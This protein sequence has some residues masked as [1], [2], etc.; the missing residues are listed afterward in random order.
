[1]YIYIYMYIYIFYIYVY[2][3]ITILIMILVSKIVLDAGSQV[4]KGEQKRESMKDYMC[5]FYQYSQFY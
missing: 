1:M 2:I 5:F 4:K 3:Y